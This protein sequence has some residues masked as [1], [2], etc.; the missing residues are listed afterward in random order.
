MNLLNDVLELKNRA[1]A[2][3]RTW[4]YHYKLI[5]EL[6]C[7]T[8]DLREENKDLRER[9]YQLEKRIRKLEGAE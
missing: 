2:S 6:C 5:T 7:D 3:S 1:D 4:Y 9:V 8:N